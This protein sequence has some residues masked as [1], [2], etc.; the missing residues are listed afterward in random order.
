MR[1]RTFARVMV[2]LAIGTSAVVAGSGTAGAAYSVDMNLACQVTYGQIGWRAT[3]AYPH[4]GGWGWRC[5]L[6]GGGGAL[7]GVDI[8]KY[9]QTVYGLHARGGSTAYNWRCDY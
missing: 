4:L 2:A 6:V 9:C 5:Y 1:A 8:E 7:K 3:L